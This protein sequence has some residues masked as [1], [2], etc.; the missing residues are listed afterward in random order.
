MRTMIVKT[1]YGSKLYGT[2]TEDS[3]T[4][5]RGVFL[6]DLEDLIF[7]DVDPYRSQVPGGDDVL[8]SHITTFAKHLAKGQPE[9]H[10]I[11]FAPRE[12]TLAS[13]PSW[14]DL[15]NHESQIVSQN[16]TPYFGFMKQQLYAT[17]Y[18]KNTYHAYRLSQELEEL[19]TIGR[20]TYPR[21]NA[22]ELRELE[23]HPRLLE[24]QHY[25]Q[26]QYDKCVRLLQTTSLPKEPDLQ[27]LHGWVMATYRLHIYCHLS[28]TQCLR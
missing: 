23:A 21:S 20:I 9:A 16:V 17:E 6:G 4:D 7:G 15:K 12:A 18:T 19:L 11:L 3:D 27:W 24:M 1:L 25:I 26:S 2:Q 22:D 28:K 10:A 5:Y 13:S 14:E 8:Y